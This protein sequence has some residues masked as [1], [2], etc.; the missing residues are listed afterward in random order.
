[1][2]PRPHGEI[3]DPEVE[4]QGR[5]IKDILGE[6]EYQ[7]RR[8]SIEDDAAKTP[9]YWLGVLTIWLGKAGQETPV[10][11]GANYSRERFRKRVTQLGAI[12]ATILEAT[13]QDGAG[14]GRGS[15]EDEA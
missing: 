12:C 1:M 4:R 14:D 7:R 3:M 11:Q 5:A 13:D 2:K 15:E 6:R 9:E 8:W 10:Y